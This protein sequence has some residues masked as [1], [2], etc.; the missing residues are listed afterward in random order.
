LNE[1]EA[2]VITTLIPKRQMLLKRPDRAKVLNLTVDPQS[3]WL[4]TSH[5]YDKQKKTEAFERY[6]LKEGLEILA[7]SSQK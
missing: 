6:G 7:R 4:Y 2:E 5:P 1:V 3:Y